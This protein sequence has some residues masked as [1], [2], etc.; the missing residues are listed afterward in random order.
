MLLIEVS[1][2][3]QTNTSGV[4]VC[5][6]SLCMHV[7]CAYMYLNILNLVIFSVYNDLRFGFK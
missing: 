1:N 2:I 4:Y 6:D 3:K 5:I 7:L